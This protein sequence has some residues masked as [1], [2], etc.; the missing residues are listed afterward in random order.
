MQL[1]IHSVDADIALL[2]YVENLPSVQV[3]CSHFY[4]QTTS[5]VLSITVQQRGTNITIN[6]TEASCE[7]QSTI[8]LDYIKCGTS[9]DL[10]L[11][12][13]PDA[14]SNLNISLCPLKTVTVEDNSFPCAG[15]N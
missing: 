7:D 5:V 13:T 9:Y 3:N 1:Q 4:D 15:K 2:G 12:W 14:S 10:V 8:H 6:S 11:S